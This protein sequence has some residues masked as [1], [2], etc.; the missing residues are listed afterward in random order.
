MVRCDSEAVE[1]LNSED[2]VRRLEAILAAY[3][4]D[5]HYNGI[6]I[7]V[8]NIDPMIFRHLAD[9]GLVKSVF[10]VRG[11]GNTW[12]LGAYFPKRLSEA[13][14]S[15][16]EG[17]CKPTARIKPE[18]LQR[19]DIDRFMAWVIEY[20]GGVFVNR[21]GEEVM[22]LITICQYEDAAI[23]FPKTCGRD[24]LSFNETSQ[25]LQDSGIMP[26]QLWL[27]DVISRFTTNSSIGAVLK[28]YKE[29]RMDITAKAAIEHKHLFYLSY[30]KTGETLNRLIDLTLPASWKHMTMRIYA[31][32]LPLYANRQIAF[33][34]VK[35]LKRV[36]GCNY[37][38]PMKG[39]YNEYV[40]VSLDKIRDL[41]EYSEFRRATNYQ[42]KI[43]QFRNYFEKRRLKSYA[44]LNTMLSDYERRRLSELEN[45]LK[46]LAEL[47]A[48]LRERGT[49]KGRLEILISLR[50]GWLKREKTFKTFN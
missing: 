46:P 33:D 6:A 19:L 37:H 9:L 38:S 5:G 22:L 12:S 49:P 21:W 31:E 30:R 40:I 34:D 11:T 29:Y 2:G 8:R 50:A 41:L 42:Q 39:P 3:L 44:T 18:V 24:R 17:Q 16:L 13:A 47:L 28:Y 20:E 35:I 15:C 10:P 26:S 36:I 43:Q 4:T 32:T 23:K 25:V 1:M 45:M 14:L 27:D 7:G 48:M